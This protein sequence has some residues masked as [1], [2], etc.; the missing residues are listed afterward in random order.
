MMGTRVQKGETLD[1]VGEGRLHLVQPKN[2]YRFSIDSLLLWG[3]LRPFPQSHWVDLGAGC[4]ILAIA[5]ARINGVERITALEL[6]PSLMRHLQRNIHLNA[7]A[8]QVI[9]VE[10]DL[11]DPRV[12]KGIPPADGVCTN[13]PYYK[14][15]AGRLNP[16]GEKARARHEIRGTLEDFIRAGSRL[17]KRGGD[18]VTI[19]PVSRLPEISPVFT[20]TRL[21]LAGL[22]FVHPRGDQP[23][24][25]VLIHA[26]KEKQREL[27]VYPPLVL[28]QSS[29]IYTP[30]TEALM[31]FEPLRYP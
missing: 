27:A 4:G 30:E 28:Y 18:F 31:R 21:P 8:N 25:H 5:L 24:T 2:G 23:A 29:Q 9:P 20:Q 7:V 1:I 22:R 13:P 3:F 17:L 19:L 11:R 15:H 26:V 14:V 6:Q 16:H 12:L 10:G